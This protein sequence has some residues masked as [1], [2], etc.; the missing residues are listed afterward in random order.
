MSLACSRCGHLIPPADLNVQTDVALCRACGHLGQVSDFA[1][2]RPSSHTIAHPPPGAWR[3]DS[4]AGP[5]F[6]ATTRS[7]LAFFLVPFMLVWTGG[8]LGGI[9][10][11]QIAKGEFDPFL[12]LF[13][14]P[15][16]AGSVIFWG[17]TLMAI[18]GRVEVRVGPDGHGEVF[19]G[20]GRFGR[21]RAFDLAEVDTITEETSIVRHRRRHTGHQHSIVLAGRTRLAFGSGLSDARRYFILQTLRS[22]HG[23]A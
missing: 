21:R 13:G 18:A 22:L 9:Y 14:L 19:T 7:P 12:S 16:I 1:S 20:V 3:R 8:S 6:G 4:F 5:V 11:T 15:F 23:P 17:I 10:G 2:P